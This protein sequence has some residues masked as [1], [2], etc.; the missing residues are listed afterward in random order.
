MSLVRTRLT[1]L[2]CLVTVMLAVLDMQ[3]VSAATVPI[4]RD[5]DPVHGLDKIPWLI[6]GFSLAATA[7]LPLLGKLA[8][9]YGAK[10]VFL[11]VLGFFLVGS[12][13]CGLAQNMTELIAARAVQG[14]GGGGLMSITMVVVAQ[15]QG[16]GGS[17]DGKRAG[18]PNPAVGGIVAGTGIALGPWVGGMLAEHANWRWIFFVN[19]PLGLVVLT[20]V[21]LAM[22]LPARPLT[23]RIDY[24]GAGLAAA[25]ASGLLLVTEWGGKQYAWSSPQLLGTAAATLALLAAFLWRQATAA[26]PVLPLSLLRD[27]TL[28]LAFTIQALIGMALVG[29]MVY[30]LIYLQ[31][32]REL[33]ATSA[34]LYLL[35]M[36]GGM[37]GVGLLTARLGWTARSQSISGTACATLALGLL[38]TLRPDS[39]L[40]FVHLAMLLLGVGLG[41]LMGQLI[42]LVQQSAP[43]QQM[44]V[45]TTA[46]RFF[47]TLGSA[48]GA[49]AFGT[50]LARV[51]AARHDGGSPASAGGA[52]PSAASLEAFT[53]ATDAVFAGAAVLTALAL[54]ASLRLPRQERVKGS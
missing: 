44:G 16:V 21:A 27:R 32:A 53:T 17:G 50:L 49:A 11:A 13:L 40:W 43:P 46:I 48:I 6:S 8:D 2:A 51:Y 34:A 47:Q 29:A 26:E 22:R 39:A 3:I 30:V 4:V 18:G 12:T 23:H 10:R 20:V 33:P 45:A 5:L 1:L 7:A 36:A 38:A 35:P 14:I 31:V 19:L 37:A 52:H 25:F 28:R 54:A 24:L 9:V 41:Q 42:V 15:L